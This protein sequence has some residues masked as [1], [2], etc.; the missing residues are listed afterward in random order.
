M[1]SS[2]A[3]GPQKKRA[4]SGKA[5][6]PAKKAVRSTKKAAVRKAKP[7]AGTARP[8][9]KAAPPKRAT[10]KKMTPTAKATSETREEAAAR[11]LEIS[12]ILSRTY[13]DARCL[14]DYQSPFQLLISTILAAQCTDERVNMVAPALYQ[15]F[16]DPL[17]MGA[18]DILELEELIRSTGFFHSKAKSIKGAASE[19]AGR[20]PGGFPRTMEELVSLPGVGR[21]TANVVLGNCFN[22]PAIIVDTHVSRVAADR[23]ALAEPGPPERIEADLQA[24]LPPEKWTRFS[25][26]VGFHG[27]KCCT[28]RGPACPWCPIRE[29][30]PW[31]LKTTQIKG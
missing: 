18:A 5:R 10:P 24:L 7:A 11:A 22:V 31:P 12:E 17:S 9:A 3:K 8:A 4:G 19:L 2:K 16:P 14:L 23:L 25:H 30:C 21:K 29:L 13:P 6:R 27:R 15:R 26:T 20:F 1:S 28:A